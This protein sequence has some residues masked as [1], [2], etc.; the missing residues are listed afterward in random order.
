[1]SIDATPAEWDA[2]TKPQH[3]NSGNIEAIVYMEGQLEGGIVDYC[4]G[5]V[6]KYIH[7]WRSKNGLQDLKKAQWYLAKL[8]EYGEKY[9]V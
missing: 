8:I 7:R 4:E 1:M 6:I 9:D 3:Y 2:V 5:N